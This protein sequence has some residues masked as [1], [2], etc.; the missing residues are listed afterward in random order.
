MASGQPASPVAELRALSD[1]IKASV[2][3]IEALC[4]ERGQT[5][6]T[7]DVPF[8]PQSEAPRMAPDVIAE[9][10]IIVAAAAQ[11]ITAVRPPP[12]SVL[13]QAVQYHVSSCMRTAILLNVP[14]I[15][16]DAGPRYGSPSCG[17]HINDIAAPSKVD[18]VKLARILRVLATKHIFKEVAP[19][20]FVH[21]RLSSVLDTGK[22]ISDI[23]ADPETK[24]DNTQ[25][26]VALIEHATD[27]G[28]QWSYH[29]PSVLTDPKWR[30]LLGIGMRGL[31]GAASNN[32]VLDGFDWKS[33]PANSVIVDVGGGIGSKML[34]LAKN[35]DHLKFIVQDRADVVGNATEF[36]K[37]EMPEAVTSGRVQLQAH[38]FF[39]PQPVREP[40]VF[41]VCTIMHDWSDKYCIKILAQLRA[42]AGKDTHLIEIPGVVFST[43]PEPLLPN[44]GE[45]GVMPYLAD[46]QMLTGQNG[47][48]RTVMQYDRIFEESGWRLTRVHMDK[49]FQSQNSKIIGV[50]LGY[51]Y[52]S[53]TYYLDSR[54]GSSSCNISTREAGV[55]LFL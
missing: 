11:L 33:L 12:L 16:R 40:A 52:C 38:D 54:A 42:A 55:Q 28:Y 46:M 26:I 9:G 2:D 37:A 14:E 21:N 10:T 7:S 19:D 47:S 20:T 41:Y 43:M 23:L 35:F 39:T 50:P 4:A 17:M 45:A 34:P 27:G 30:K 5:Y 53:N 25:G 36:W 13:T 49:G 51:I 32:I 29:L 48:E 6:P 15:L 44:K 8:S 24:H 31:Q 22:N 3:K 1:L 18:P